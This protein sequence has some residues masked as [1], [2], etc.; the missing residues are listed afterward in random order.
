MSRPGP[1]H[2]PLLGAE[3][4]VTRA[5]HQQESSCADLR[6]LGAR[7]VSIPTIELS[8]PPPALSEIY[9][10][11]SLV[12]VLEAGQKFQSFDWVI[13]TSANAVRHSDQEWARLGG[14]AQLLA[15]A[16]LCNK[17]QVVCVGSST[18]RALSRRVSCPTLTPV[19]FHAEGVIELFKEI[20]LVG[21]RILIP[22]A[23]HAREALPRAL[24]LRGAEVYIA[25]VYQTLPRALT[26]Q[27]RSLLFTESGHVRYLTLT[28][29]STLSSLTSQI[30]E[31][32]LIHL[33]RSTRVMVIGPVVERATLKSGLKVQ[34][35]AQPHTWRGLIQAM[36]ADFVSMTP[37]Q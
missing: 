10:D 15:P 14:L 17:P 35:V 2:L 7:S 26:P 6:A 29:D 21:K 34:R 27:M 25:P 33:N 23:L 16:T 3:V 8:P 31:R 9:Q 22:R 37:S 28:S 30:S 5:P 11:S 32:D 19:N 12:F 20:P 24:R 4:F 13:F 1:P 18:Q 36:I